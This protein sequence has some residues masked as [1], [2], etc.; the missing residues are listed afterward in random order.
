MAELCHV[1]IKRKNQMN[2]YRTACG[3]TINITQQ[4][5]HHLIA[6]PNVVELLQAAIGEIH[7]PAVRRKIEEEIDVGRRIGRSGIVK[8]AP[9]EIG[10]PALFSLRA[11]RKLPSRVAG[12]GELGEATSK[13]VVVARPSQI[14][15]QYDLITSWIGVLAKKE[16]WDGSI[17]ERREFQECLGFWSTTA[18]IYDP[19][20]MGPVFESSWKDVLSHGRCRFL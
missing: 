17:A 5:R 4:A 7:L 3:G 14:E 2:Q 12:V 6:H 1:E 15:N 18:L 19:A 8:T 10:E 20:V 9:L 13:I 11:N 16:P